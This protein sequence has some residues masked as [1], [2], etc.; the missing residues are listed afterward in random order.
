MLPSKKSRVMPGFS[1]F[2]TMRVAV[3]AGTTLG[4]REAVGLDGRIVA[5]REFGASA[6]LKD[7]LREFGFTVENVVAHAKSLLGK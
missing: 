4:W 6:P 7:L 1:S 3:E 5:R 2:P